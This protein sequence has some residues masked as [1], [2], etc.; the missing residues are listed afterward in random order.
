MCLKQEI[1]YSV[2]FV[3]CYNIFRNIPIR[4]W[5]WYL[6]LRRTDR[7]YINKVVALTVIHAITVKRTSGACRSAY[8]RITL[9]DAIVVE[10]RNA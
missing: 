1:E 4:S 6:L 7:C 2:Y 10:R 3:K 5:P 9:Q 8:R